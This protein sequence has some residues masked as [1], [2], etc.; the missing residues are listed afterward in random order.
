MLHLDGQLGQD[1]LLSSGARLRTKSGC[2]ECRRRRK[3]CDEKRPRCGGCT[4]ND[5]ECRWPTES[6]TVDRRR[7]RKT[8]D[9][10]QGLSSLASGTTTTSADD[11]AHTMTTVMVS[12]GRP[13]RSLPPPVSMPE[14][15]HK[16]EHLRIYRYFRHFMSPKLVRQTSLSRYSQDFHI[17]RLAL[18]HPP[19]MGALIALTGMKMSSQS[20]NLQSLALQSYLFAITSIKTALMEGRHTGTEDWLLATTTLLCLFENSRCDAMPNAR[21]HVLASGQMLS[22]RRPKPRNAS[23]EAIVFERICVESFLYHAALL[24]LFDPS[25]DCL[26]LIKGELN[27]E[28]YFSDPDHPDD[29]P[30]GTLTSTQPV[31][32]ASYKFF[33]LVL[34]VTKLAQS[35][36][37]TTIAEFETWSRLQ[38]MVVHWEKTID[39]QQTSNPE[40]HV[41][42]LY[43]VAIRILLVYTDPRCSMVDWVQ[44]ME[45]YLLRGLETITSLVVDE[46]FSF[47]YLWPLLVVGSVAVLQEEKQIVQA[48]L[49]QV[50]NTRQG[51]PISLAHYRLEK[52]WRSG[53]QYSDSD[54]GQV[55]ARQ[56][57]TL[58]KED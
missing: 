55:M 53:A 10:Q 18:A 47:Y 45:L 34:D 2:G 20:S 50:S 9:S 13:G 23:Q 6:Q 42:R 39:N 31:L 29:I 5:F 43:A 12:D 37:L 17:A 32:D 52:V 49:L 57:Q 36:P 58:L 7:H 3:K 26:P 30:P 27:L 24:T 33:L 8:S 56:L 46:W 40:N 51:G 38:D 4:R 21:S 14:P 41:G 19:L 25:V 48:K 54:R 16:T 35:S 1:R 15:F 44:S 22:L 11:G 28:G